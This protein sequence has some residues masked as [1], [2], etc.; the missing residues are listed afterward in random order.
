MERNLLKKHWFVMLNDLKER[1][2][3]MTQS[4]LEYITGDKKKLVEVVQKRKH[5]PAEEALRDVEEF[6]STASP[7]TSA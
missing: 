6:L 1:W 2:P 7:A 4:D 5:I 3:D